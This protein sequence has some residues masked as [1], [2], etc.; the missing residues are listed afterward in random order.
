V[1]QRNNTCTMRQ[2]D[3]LQRVGYYIQKIAENP[4]SGT[5]TGEV[6]ED[7]LG[8]AGKMVRP[9]LLQTCS[10]LGPNYAEQLDRLCILAAMVEL[11]HLSSLIHDDIIDDAPVRRGRSSVQSKYGKDAAVYAG[12]FLISRIQYWQA[13]EV[14]NA[15]A[16][17]L[18]KTVEDMCIG[19]IGQDLCRYRETV[20]VDEYY[21]NINRKTASLFQ[22]ACAAGA[23]EA[24]CSDEVVEVL[25]RFGRCLG[26]MFQL[27]DDLLDFL[28]SKQ[29][30]GKET[31]KDFQDGIYTLPVLMAMQSE[32]GKAALLPILAENSRRVLSEDEIRD[33]EALVCRFGGVEA[34]RTEIHRHCMEGH[35]LLD[36]LGDHEAVATL[37][38][39]LDLLDECESQ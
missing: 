38:K 4:V 25:A 15:A 34:T 37:R 27:R 13:K 16:M 26:I 10:S 29:D 21:E 8:A 19:E 12:D 14:L 33:M 11:T 22:C 17:R 32:E 2:E 7:A 18:A 30:M 23:A 3:A 1:T 5:P 24:G 20:S 36:A 35:R 9:R 28:S 6:L 39:M 31:H